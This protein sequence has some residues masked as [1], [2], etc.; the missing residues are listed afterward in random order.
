MSP[1]AKEELRKR[2]RMHEIEAEV[3]AER[4]TEE[5]AANLGFKANESITG[6]RQSDAAYTMLERRGE[7]LDQDTF[8]VALDTVGEFPDDVTTVREPARTPTQP[9]IGGELDREARALLSRRGL[10]MTAE[11]YAAALTEVAR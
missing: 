2:L 4:L 5:A 9:A 3:R 11:S 7:Q 10:E 8:F 6:L 1:T